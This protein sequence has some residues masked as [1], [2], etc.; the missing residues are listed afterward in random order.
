MSFAVAENSAV[1]PVERTLAMGS[2]SK[3]S[4]RRSHGASHCSAASAPPASAASWASM[5]RRTCRCPGSGR[6]STA[7]SSVARRSL[8]SACGA[9]TSVRWKSF[10]AIGKEFTCLVGVAPFHSMSMMI[11]PL[12]STRNGMASSDVPRQGPSKQ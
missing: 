11:Q 2:I 9:R 6:T 4:G 5:H 3:S 7:V 1:H 10:S 12:S 8:S